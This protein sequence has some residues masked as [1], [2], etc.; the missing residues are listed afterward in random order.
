MKFI[1]VTCPNCGAKLEFEDGI[2]TFFCQHCGHQIIADGL[3]PE[4]IREKSKIEQLKL[5]QQHEREMAE[6]RRAG[7]NERMKIY[8]EREDKKEEREDKRRRRK[9][10]REF[11]S[12]PGIF[13][14]I[15]LMAV[16]LFVSTQLNTCQQSAQLENIE[17][18][19]EQHIDNEEFDEARKDLIKL[20]EQNTGKSS[21]D[22]KNDEGDGAQKTWNEKIA[23]YEKLIADKE[24]ESVTKSDTK[25]FAPKSSEDLGKMSADDAKKLCAG[26]RNHDLIAL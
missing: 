26:A 6:W 17:A 10:I 7:R 2:D 25:S 9:E 23:Y 8:N 15:F 20:K 18:S 21:D 5:K 16:A 4:I 11:I 13:V 19:I 12:S 3:N 14:V 24:R 1:S 22:K